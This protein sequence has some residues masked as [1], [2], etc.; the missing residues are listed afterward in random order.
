MRCVE[1]YCEG[2]AI[3]TSHNLHM[4]LFAASNDGQGAVAIQAGADYTTALLNPLEFLERLKP[5]V[6]PLFPKRN[7]R[8]VVERQP[9]G[10]LVRM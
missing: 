6:E 10:H 8:D 2:F 4:L 5:A 9:L 7:G 1:G 3:Y